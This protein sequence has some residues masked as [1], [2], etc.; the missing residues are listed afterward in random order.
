MKSEKRMG[1]RARDTGRLPL[2]ERNKQRN[3]QRI[4]AAAFELFHTTGYH[5][6]TMDTIAEKAEA[7]AAG[8][9]PHCGNR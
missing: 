1:E 4:V 3:F 5:E 2:R 8:I 9:R 7:L 6:T